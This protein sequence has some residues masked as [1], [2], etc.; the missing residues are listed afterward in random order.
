MIGYLEGSLLAQLKDGV[1]LN[2]AGGVGYQVRLPVPLLAQPMKP[3]A[4]LRF[5]V[6]TVVREDDIS[7]YGF[8]DVAGKAMFEALITVSGV[9]PKAALA[10]LSAFSPGELTGAIVRQDVPLLSTIPGIGRKTAT[11]LCL[12]LC[13][14]LTGESPALEGLPES[15]GEL[16]SALTNLGFQEKDVLTVLQK[17][18]A[19]SRSFS[20]QLKQALALL[21]KN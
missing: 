8:S 12:E 18:P 7:L 17:L 21:G 14:R 5:Y 1:L 9:G 6:V 19:D 11:R 16:M 15:R 4:T 2:T 3:G 20:D 10:F 13:D